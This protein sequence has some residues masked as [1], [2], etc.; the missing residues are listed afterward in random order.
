M[1]INIYI[2]KIIIN[3][4]LNRVNKIFPEKKVLTFDEL[5]KEVRP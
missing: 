1:I 5:I 4:R 2:T 3:E